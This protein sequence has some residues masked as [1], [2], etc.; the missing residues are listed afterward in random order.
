[1][2]AAYA[3][4]GLVYVVDGLASA[5]KSHAGHMVTRPNAASAAFP[6]IMPFFLLLGMRVL[7][8]LPV[9]AGANW[10]FRLVVE[11]H[12]TAAPR[13]VRKLM[14]AAGVAPVCAVSLLMYGA[15]WGW[16]LALSHVLLSVLLALIL[17]QAL[18]TGFHKIPFTCTFMP[19][20]ANLKATF[21]I[22]VVV[23]LMAAFLIVNLELWLLGSAS[24]TLAGAAAAGALLF[25]TTRRR[26]KEE[27]GPAGRLIYEERANWQLNTLDLT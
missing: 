21:A 11:D 24:R 8:T 26:E 7:F 12:S 4:L 13:G 6:L 2:L 22:Y 20:K 5:L 1:M 17:L 15:V 27:S 18:I 9:E 25:W 3:S 16:R 14:I 10:L 19:G 23:F